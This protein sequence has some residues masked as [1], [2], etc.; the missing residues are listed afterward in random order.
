M[1]RLYLFDLLIVDRDRNYESMSDSIG[2]RKEEDDRPLIQNAA[3]TNF[4]LK[5]L[6]CPSHR[7]SADYTHY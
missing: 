3:T 4:E 2:S 5:K 1:L 7:L 6:I